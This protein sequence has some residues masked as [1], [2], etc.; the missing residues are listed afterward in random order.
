MS[1]TTARGVSRDLTKRGKN[2]DYP[3]G[4]PGLKR[5]APRA[6]YFTK[7]WTPARER[8]FMIAISRKHSGPVKP[9]EEVAS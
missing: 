7:R 6:S 5:G 2:P 9:A 1:T 3:Y 8:E 4:L